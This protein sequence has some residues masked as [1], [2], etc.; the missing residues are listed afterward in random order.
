MLFIYIIY[1]SF[2][3]GYSST[4][5]N[6]CP[7]LK[8][9]CICSKDLTIINCTNRQL[10]NNLL[11]KVNNDL[12]NRTKFLNLSSNFLTSIKSLSNLKSLEILDLSYNKIHYIPSNIFTKFPQLTTL[13]IQN[14]SIRISL[15]NFLEIS[16]QQSQILNENKE[17]LLNC[18]SNFEHYWTL[19]NQ[20][21]PSTIKTTLY[22]IIFIQHLK[23]NHSG[24]WTCHSKN[25]N[26]SIN[27]TVRKNLS[28]SFCQSIQMNTSK[29]YF[30]WPR[31]IINKKLEKKC[32]FGSAAW[33]L[34]NSN[35]YARAW[36]T[37]SSNGQWKNFDI[38]QCGYQTNISRI[39]DYLSLNQTNLLINLIKYLSKIN[40]NQMKF[41]DIILLI[42]LIDEQQEKSK[43]QDKIMLIYH[44][45]DFILQIKY[46]IISNYQY[47]LALTRFSKQ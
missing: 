22:S 37:C 20:F 13:Y 1:I 44:L 6:P 34:S 33:W 15:E 16:P 24:I 9:Y 32:P 17:F 26:R 12:P 7:K 23:L 38:S 31:T 27:L 39:F 11:L 3:I 5:N 8:K 21:Y 46:D 2:L 40:S 25:K 14:N 28:N 41:D 43:S 4:D 19:N 36:F 42:D 29:G 35:E 10:T 45:T 18:S 30:Y 47:Q